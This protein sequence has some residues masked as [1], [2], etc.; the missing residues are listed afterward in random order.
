MKDAER[1]LAAADRDPDRVEALAQPREEGARRQ[2]GEARLDDPLGDA[3]QRPLVLHPRDDVRHDAS[4][5]GIWIGQG[6]NASAE[7]GGMRTGEGPPDPL[8]QTPVDFTSTVVA[9]CRDASQDAAEPL[10]ELPHH[11]R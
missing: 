7:G 5:P 1:D 4:T 9:A 6:G 8:L 11:D 3:E 2:L 10:D